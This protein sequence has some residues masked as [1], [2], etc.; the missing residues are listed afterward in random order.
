MGLT[1]QLKPMTRRALFCYACLA[2]TYITLIFVLPAS[3]ATTD[4]YSLSGIEY[5]VILSA[6]A[7]PSLIAWFAAFLSYAKLFDY[8]SSIRKTPEGRSYAELATGV[9]W[10]AWSLPVSAIAAQ[11][12]GAIANHNL[13]FRPAS[14]IISNYITLTL[15][16]VAFVIISNASRRLATHSKLEFTSSSTRIIMTAFIVAGVTY[17]YFI[18]RNFDISSFSSTQNAYYLPLWLMVITLIVPYMYAWFIG[19]LSVYEISLV[20]RKISGLIYRQALKYLAIGLV[21]V[22]VSSIAIHYLN[23]IQPRV[24]YLL[25]DSKL[26]FGTLLRLIRG[27]GFVMIVYGALKLKKIEEV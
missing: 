12:L 19:F 13:G 14:I 5:K 23:A 17:C 9:T 10:L 18:L 16:L 26:L 1:K 27:I 15:L 25:I 11:L 20:G 7:I 4:K 24:G 21:I 8:A 3:Q 2:V 22:I 6:I